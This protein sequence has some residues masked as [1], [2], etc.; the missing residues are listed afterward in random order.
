MKPTQSPFASTLG[1]TIFDV[2]APTNIQPFGEL[3]DLTCGCTERGA[4]PYPYVPMPN[5]YGAPG[6]IGQS[7]QRGQ[8][9]IFRSSIEECAMHGGYKGYPGYVSYDV[10]S[11]QLFMRNGLTAQQPEPSI[12]KS[13]G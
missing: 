7:V 13:L 10:A 9:V 2:P 5:S 11:D 4:Y 3:A 12:Y 8:T 1:E 6:E